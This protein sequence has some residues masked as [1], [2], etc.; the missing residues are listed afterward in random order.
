MSRPE[1]EDV[2]S[3]ALR[4]WGA[5][6]DDAL[7][8]LLRLLDADLRR[9]ARQRLGRLNDGLRPG[10]RKASLA[11]GE[12]VREMF[13]RLSRGRRDWVNRSHFFAI[14][15]HQMRNICRD[16]ARE[17][18]AQKRGGDLQRV[19]A[20]H[21]LSVAAPPSMDPADLLALDAAL[22]ALTA[23]DARQASVVEMLFFAGLTTEEVAAA[24]DMSES[25]VKR[26][27]R[28]ARAW[29]RAFLDGMPQS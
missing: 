28:S 8:D 4:A 26:E 19:S 9:M 20:S 16:H 1:G 12:V 2:V 17:I 11:S 7:A 25:T 6:D 23:L 3:E 22:T 18:L 15:A 10:G 27:W 5:G 29:L 24:L 14:A 21:L 13:M